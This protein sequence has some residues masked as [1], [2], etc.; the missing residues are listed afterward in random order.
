VQGSR[1]EVVFGR[2]RVTEQEVAVKL[3]LISGTLHV[4]REALRWLTDHHGPVPRLCTASATTLAD[5]R[6]VA[7]LVTE[8]VRGRRPVGDDGWRQLGSALAKLS[9]IPWAGS[10]LSVRDAATFGREHAERVA[11]LGLRLAPAAARV[12]DWQS[13]IG[14]RVPDPAPLVLT[15][16]DPGPGNFIHHDRHGSLIDWEEA[17]VAPRGLDIARAMFLAFL[18][19][20]DPAPERCRARARCAARGYLADLD[21]PWVPSVNDLRWWLTVAGIQFAFRRWEREGQDRVRPAAEA[22]DVLAEMLADDPGWLSLSPE[23][24]RALERTLTV[25]PNARR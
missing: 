4:E 21:E 20:E 6:R 9:A 18:R 2:E 16:G 10:A 17:Q 13:L 22:V 14:P 5:G 12:P 7:C 8:R 15:H 1:H 25:S 11:A 3:E 19:P 23:G 24:E